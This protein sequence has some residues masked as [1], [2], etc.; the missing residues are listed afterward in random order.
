MWFINFLASALPLFRAGQ[1]AGLGYL[2]NQ[3]MFT[4]YLAYRT[5]DK[6]VRDREAHK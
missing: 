6:A 3:Q 1:D 5:I 2:F 4:E